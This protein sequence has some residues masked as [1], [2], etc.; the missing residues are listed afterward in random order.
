M[1]RFVQGMNFKTQYQLRIGTVPFPN[2]IRLS[3]TPLI[4]QFQVLPDLDTGGT[5]YVEVHLI[6]NVSTCIVCLH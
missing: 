6:T 1:G 3:A 4:L 2:R 5:L